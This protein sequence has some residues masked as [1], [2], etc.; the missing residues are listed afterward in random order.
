[1]SKPGFGLSQK[2]FLPTPKP[3]FGSPKNGF[4]SSSTPVFSRRKTGFC[5]FLNRFSPPQ[6]PV[7]ADV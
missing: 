6:K 4:F 1:M 2:R 7:F 3:V 5:G